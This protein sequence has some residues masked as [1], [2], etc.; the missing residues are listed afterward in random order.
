MILAARAL[1]LILAA[2]ALVSGVVLMSRPSRGGAAV[3]YA[4]PMHPEISGAAP[5]QCAICRMALER[6]R[7]APAAGPPDRFTVPAGAQDRLFA[8]VMGVRAR[9]VS[10][11]VVAPAWVEGPAA[12]IAHLYGDEL[13][14]LGPGEEAVFVAGGGRETRVRLGGEPAAD[15][16]GTTAA[17]RLRASGATP[18]A[19]TVGWVR[20]PSRT[21]AMLAVPTS[22]LLQGT[23]GPYVLVASPDR[24]TFTRRPVQIG[25]A[26]YGYAPVLSGLASGERVAVMEAFFIDAERRLGHGPRGPIPAAPR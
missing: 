10:R 4:C 8:D 9:P 16:D 22:A 25:R 15:W 13:A 3:V 19:G 6:R 12:V 23:S 2:A 26:R 18:P 24:H 1:L 20:F 21:R 5:G 11:A 17:V 14:L 7:A